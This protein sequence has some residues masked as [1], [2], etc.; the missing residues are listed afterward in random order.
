[1]STIEQDE[2]DG[3]SRDLEKSDLDELTKFAMKRSLKVSSNA[4]DPKP[5]EDP[6]KTLALAHA[7]LAVGMS[8]FMI[9][10]RKHGTEIVKK[11]VSEHIVQCNN[12]LSNIANMS[13]GTVL[14]QIALRSPYAVALVAVVFILK[15]YGD[16]LLSLS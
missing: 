2:L 4:I 11:A 7:T 3:A 10:S 14:K 9:G 13:W 6:I 8:H 15:G 16:K 12:R 1:M 5:G